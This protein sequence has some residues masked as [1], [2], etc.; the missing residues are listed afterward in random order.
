MGQPVGV[1]K[2]QGLV[3]GQWNQGFGGAHTT[4][5]SRVVELPADT[6]PPPKKFKLQHL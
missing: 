2:D 4:L 1:A 5:L 6:S 3:V